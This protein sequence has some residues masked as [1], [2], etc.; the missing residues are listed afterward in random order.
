MAELR[1]VIAIEIN[2]ISH[3]ALRIA[4]QNLQTSIAHCA[5][6]RIATSAIAMRN[7]EIDFIY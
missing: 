2:N 4:L 7:A 1:I 3:C 6:Q 5:L